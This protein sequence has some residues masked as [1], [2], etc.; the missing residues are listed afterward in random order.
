LARLGSAERNI[1]TAQRLLDAGSDITAQN[2]D[3]KTPLD[4]LLGNRLRNP[5]LVELFRRHAGRGSPAR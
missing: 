4:I 5:R 3:G 2:N 1:E